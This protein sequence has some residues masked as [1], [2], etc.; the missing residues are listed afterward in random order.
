MELLEFLKTQNI[1]S[2]LINEVEKFRAYYKL[3]KDLEYRIPEVNFKFYGKEVWEKAI[4][5]ILSGNHILLTGPKATGKNVLSENLSTLF[6]R[7]LWTISLNVNTDSASLIGTDTFKD[8]TVT[9]KKGPVYECGEFGGFGVFDEINMAK[10]EALSVVHSALDYRRI[11]D[12]SGYGRLKLHEATRFIATMNHGYIGT[13]DLNE[14]LVSRFMVIEMPTISEE[15]LKLVLR[16]KT[17]LKEEYV[18]LF[19]RFF[20][21]IEL[22][23][24]NSEISSKPIDLRGLLGAIKLMEM[25]L[26]INSAIEM[27]I[28]H[29]SF[30]AYESE[31]VGDVLKTLIRK[32][33]KS[34]DLFNE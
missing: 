1:D 21:D 20:L 15:N 12:V 28:S 31:I 9:L 29:K 26:G 14:A 16:D 27:G 33:L 13:R 4:A 2:N 5:G 22:K 17:N 6:S 19:T 8:N 24:L 32:D 10:N 25:G 30:D 18:E 34:E 11:I 3:D 7:P 23:S